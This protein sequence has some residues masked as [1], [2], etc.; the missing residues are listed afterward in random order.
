MGNFSDDLSEAE[1]DAIHAYIVQLSREAVA[2][3]SE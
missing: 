3:Q 2:A 1:V